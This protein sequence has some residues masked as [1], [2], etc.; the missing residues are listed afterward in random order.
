[1][2]KTSWFPIVCCAALLMGCGNAAT[3]SKSQSSSVHYTPV[4]TS[5]T[6]T[7]V[8]T[9]AQDAKALADYIFK[10]RD[11]STDLENTYDKSY[12]LNHDTSESFEGKSY[13]LV[14]FM[15][16]DTISKSSGSHVFSLSASFNTANYVISATASV[17][18]DYGSLT[19]KTLT[20]SVSYHYS[21]GTYMGTI[22][23]SNVV[24]GAQGTITSAS[25][26][27]KKFEGLSGLEAMNSEDV[28]T[29]QSACVHFYNEGVTYYQKQVLA[30]GLHEIH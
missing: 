29:L 16:M 27:F 4:S 3:A 28:T 26:S 6:P 7:S 15:L 2:K 30:S 22:V 19:S 1:M 12:W 21:N 5:Y 8:D 25:V 14:S 13:T 18:F 11:P 20:G 9:T 23:S 24:F 17:L 10:Q